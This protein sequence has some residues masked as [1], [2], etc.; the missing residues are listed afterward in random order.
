VRNQTPA[1]GLVLKADGR[2]A[3]SLVDGAGESGTA[4]VRAPLVLNTTGM[5]IDRVNAL[6]TKGAKRRVTGTKGTHLMVQAARGMPRPGRHRGV[7]R[8]QPALH[9]SLAQ[10]ALHRADRYSVRRLRG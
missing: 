8:R 10:H 9:L 7:P 6:A 3:V 1:T 2:W 5:W 4:T